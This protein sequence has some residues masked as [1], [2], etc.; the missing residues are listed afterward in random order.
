MRPA[1]S[2]HTHRPRVS[3]MIDKIYTSGDNGLTANGVP[4]E[5]SSEVYVQVTVKEPL[6]LSPFLVGA[7]CEGHQPGIYGINNINLTIHF[8]P[9]A[10]RAWR[11]APYRIYTAGTA[12]TNANASFFGKEVT[13]ARVIEATI[14]TKFYTPK[15]SQ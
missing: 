6:F 13:L 11:S 12:L 1:G 14:E 3:F 4:T 7:D 10:N 2:S 15:G 8:L 5:G 9:S